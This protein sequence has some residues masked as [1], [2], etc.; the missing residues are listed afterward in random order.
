MRHYLTN[1]FSVCILLATISWST[2]GWPADPGPANPEELFVLSGQAYRPLPAVEVTLTT[3]V[4]IPGAQ[5]GE[6][7][8]RYVLGQDHEAVLDIGPMLRVV[9]NDHGVFAELPG[10][11]DRFLAI[12]T[13]GGLADRLA[14][15][16]GKSSLAGLWVPVPA[17][18]RAGESTAEILDALRYSRHLGELTVA[19]FERLEGPVYEVLLEAEN[20]SCRVRFNGQTFY[21][22]EVEYLVEPA[23]TPDGYTV[24]IHGRFETR[25]IDYDKSLFDFQGGDR[26][27]VDTLRAL[28]PKPPGITRPAAEIVSPQL[29]SEHLVEIDTLAASL[30]Q[31]DVLLVGEDHLYE[32]PP[33]YLVELLKRLDDRPVSLLL[34]LPTDIQDDIDR[35]MA[36][37][38]ED[39][40]ENIFKGRQVLQLQSLLRWAQQNSEQVPV[41][42]AIDEPLYEI[43]LKRAYLTDTRNPTMASAIHREWQANPDHRIVFYAGQL[44]LMKAGRYKVN[45]ASRNTAGSR[46][47]LLGVPADRIAVVWLNGGENFHLHSVWDQPGVLALGEFPVR[48]PM[49]Y[50]IDYPVFGIDYADE[51]VDYFVNLGSLTRIEVEM[52]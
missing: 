51:A 16:R 3:S 28:S 10:H 24:R 6:R 38:G 49:A 36:D 27:A 32:E 45:R 4:E 1:T 35:Y 50:F 19:G 37:G 5:T 46:L 26:M 31:E 17:A 33:L 12:E 18:L 34:E 11:A 22:D 13:E 2:A 15:V 21:V 9:S 14:L 25:A 48:V 40:L 30:K 39:M 7:V 23:K 44:H 41:V 47:P 42:R 43:F 20:G 8:T 29:L 52:P